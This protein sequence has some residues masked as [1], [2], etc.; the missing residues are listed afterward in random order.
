[1]CRQHQFVQHA[2]S[3][4]QAR[5]AVARARG[6]W[7]TQMYCK[8]IRRLPRTHSHN[9]PR[10]RNT[11]SRLDRGCLVQVVL[12]SVTVVVVVPFFLSRL[13]DNRGLGGAR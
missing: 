8:S 10:N 5:P 3:F 6:A 4:V 12:V 1:L 9:G 7:N 13:L 2:D 11:P